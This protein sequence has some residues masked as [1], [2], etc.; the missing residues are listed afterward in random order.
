MKPSSSG[1]DT[2]QGWRGIVEHFGQR[3]IPPLVAVDVQH[4]FTTFCVDRLL[5]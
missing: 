2:I 1:S 4:R 5:P 3:L